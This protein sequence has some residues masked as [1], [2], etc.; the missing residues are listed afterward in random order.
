MCAYVSSEM[1][2]FPLLSYLS[3]LVLESLK[4]ASWLIW[5]T[6]CSDYPTALALCPSLRLGNLSTFCLYRSIAQNVSLGHWLRLVPFKFISSYSSW[7]IFFISQFLAG[8]FRGDHCCQNGKYSMSNINCNSQLPF[9]L[10]FLFP[11]DSDMMAMSN[12]KN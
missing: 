10:C 11:R 7:V 3:K 6:S 12:L 8:P 4:V 5:R 1:E 2:Y 9:S